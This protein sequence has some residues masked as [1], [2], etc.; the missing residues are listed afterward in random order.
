MGLIE[1]FKN[2]GGRGIV[3]YYPY[4]LI[5]PELKIG[6]KENQM[7]IKHYQ[8]TAKKLGLLESG[9]SDFHGGDRETINAVEIPGAVLEKLKKAR[10]GG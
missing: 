2:Q 7:I 5:C 10:E 6:E 1:F 8:A 4:H 9:G 3:S